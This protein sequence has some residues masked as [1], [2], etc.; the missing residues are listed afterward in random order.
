MY[1]VF[2]AM[3]AIFFKHQFFRSIQL[4]SLRNVILGFADS[5]YQGKH[6]PLFFFSHI[7]IIPQFG[8]VAKWELRDEVI[9]LESFRYFLC[10]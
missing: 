9:C 2:F 7:A 4:I 8:H 6:F 3:P 5:T 1:C 10:E